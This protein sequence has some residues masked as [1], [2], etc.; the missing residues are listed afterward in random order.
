MVIAG[1]HISSAQ[2]GKLSRETA[3]VIKH[4]GIEVEGCNKTLAEKNNTAARAAFRRARSGG[5]A[6]STGDSSARSGR[7]R[8]QSCQ[9]TLSGGDRFNQ[10]GREPVVDPTPG[11]VYLGLW[12]K[13]KKS[14]AVLLLPTKNI[15]D[16]GMSGTIESLGLTAKVPACYDY[17]GQTKEFRWA[18]GY[19]D[20]GA[21]VAKREFPVLY[22]D[23][24][25]KC[26]VG[27]LG[28]KDLMPFDAES[29]AA[30]DIPHIELVRDFLRKRARE[31]SA[32]TVDS[33][34]SMSQNT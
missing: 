5:Q 26:G 15:G 28:A 33:S 2:H 8:T 14:W 22:F 20:G 32:D 1:S 30:S 29:T 18:E 7:S 21:L 34:V 16:V 17:D 23:G 11:D 24:Q 3:V 6:T 31:V 25:R 19:E 12:G 10:K 27:W 13:A 9:D 4:F